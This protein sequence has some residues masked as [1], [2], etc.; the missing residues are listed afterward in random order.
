MKGSTIMVATIVSTLIHFFILT[1]LDTVPLISKEIPQRNLYMV[2]LVPLAVEQPAPQKEEAPPVPQPVEEAKKEEVKK[3]EEKKEEVKKE[4]VKKEEPKRETVKKE[5]V[6]KTPPKDDEVVLANQDKKQEKKEAPAKQPSDSEKQRLAS[7]EEIKKNVA[8]REQGDSQVTDDEIE[9]YVTMVENTVKGLWVIPDLLS[10]RE[11]KAV[12]IFGIDKQGEVV[13]LRFKQ[14][15]GNTPY[16]QSV[17]RAI[18]KAAPFT[19]P[20]QVLLTEEYELTFQP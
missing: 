20:L 12:V 15:S 4:E 7:I 14:S 5:E 1:L 3:E 11:L 9:Q 10:A 19:P 17:I 6:E 13:N 8:A 18:R 16:D 2:D